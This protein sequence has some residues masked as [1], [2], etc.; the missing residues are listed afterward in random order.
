MAIS[1]TESGQARTRSTYMHLVQIFAAT[2]LSMQPIEAVPVRLEA[3]QA[4]GK[5]VCM[6]V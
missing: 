2:L 4:F 6:P 1:E 3:A 5:Y